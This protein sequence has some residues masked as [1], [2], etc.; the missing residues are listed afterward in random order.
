[1]IT[2][3]RNFLAASVIFGLSSAAPATFAQSA[4]QTSTTSPPKPK[5]KPKKKPA[6]EAPK[7][8]EPA[9]EPP[10]SADEETKPATESAP[11][12]TSPTPPSPADAK[13]AT[14]EAKPAHEEATEAAAGSITDTAQ[15]PNQR[16]L[17]I[18]LHYRGTVIPQFLLNLFVDQGKTLYSNTIAAELDVRKGGQS[19][20]PWIAYTEYGTGDVL[21][22]QKGQ[23][24]TID[25]N[26]SVIN[27]GLKAIYLGLD[28]LWSIPLDKSHHFDFEYGFGVGIGFLFGDL[29][30]NWV[31]P[32]GNGGQISADNFVACQTVTSGRGCSTADHQN[33][34]TA[35]V[36]GFVE[37]NW[38]HG[39]AV[40]VIFPHVAFPQLSLRYEPIKQVEARLS[41]GFSL[42]GF[43]FGL[44]ADYGLEKTDEKPVKASRSRGAR[45]DML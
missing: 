33:T 3:H 23:D 8:A 35:K 24:P 12:D 25:G 22:L 30:N 19:M 43:W 21:F 10:K 2:L 39:G 20:I 28:E 32:G 31:T 13:P 1:M 4:D 26:W 7:P 9:P 40:P 29:M 44:S 38:F 14:D 11:A 15:D 37:P 42:T 41:V 16:Y 45:H 27:S 36:G 17:F 5:K 6:H 18:G 34:T